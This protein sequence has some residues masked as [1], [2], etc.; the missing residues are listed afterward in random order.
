[1]GTKRGP[2][3]KM[4]YM[5]PS[6]FFSVASNSEN[7]ETAVKFIDGVTKNIDMNTEL[8][9]ERGVPSLNSGSGYAGCYL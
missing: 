7:P 6:Q 3:G 2:E 1:M 9:A 4:Q 5:K 8:K